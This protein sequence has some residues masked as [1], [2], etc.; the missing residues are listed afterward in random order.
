MP[1]TIRDRL[2]GTVATAVIHLYKAGTQIDELSTAFQEQHPEFMPCLNAAQAHTFAAYQELAKFF[3]SAW[4]Y[5]PDDW[6]ATR[7]RK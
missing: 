2:K 3:E 4:G 1:K 6:Y 5:V 7:D